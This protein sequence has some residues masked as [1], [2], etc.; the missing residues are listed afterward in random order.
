MA[1]TLQYGSIGGTASANVPVQG[2]VQVELPIRGL[3]SV[4]SKS[5]KE[6][7]F[8][9]RSEFPEYGHDNI[10]YVDTDGNTIYYWNVDSYVALSGGSETCK[11]IA[12]TT[13]EWAIERTLLSDYGSIY[14]YTDYRQESGVNIP[15][16]KIGD[17]LAYV[18]DLPFFDTGVTEADRLRWDNKV[19]VMLS[20]IDNENLILYT[21]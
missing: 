10:L 19:S 14:I 8:L 11:I 20:P 3:V 13:A 16:I 5:V 2:L 4:G 21:D 12:K 7:R 17:G 15:A 1:N 18:V 9:P 6:L